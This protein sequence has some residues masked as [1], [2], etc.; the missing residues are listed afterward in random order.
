LATFSYNKWTNPK[1]FWLCEVKVLISAIE[2]FMGQLQSL[3]KDYMG[4]SLLV[5]WLIRKFVLSVKGV[6]SHVRKHA[7]TVGE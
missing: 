5:R 3:V 2:S 4:I 7:E 1:E 6:W